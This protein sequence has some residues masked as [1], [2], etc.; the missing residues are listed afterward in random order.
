[1]ITPFDVTI[2]MFLSMLIGV[3]SC[4]AYHLMRLYDE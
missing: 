2:I 3:L 4:E 1:M